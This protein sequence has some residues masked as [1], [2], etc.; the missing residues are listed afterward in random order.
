MATSPERWEAVK[1]LFEAAL[2]ED[3]ARRSSFLEERCNDAGVRAEVERLLA[4]HAQAGVFLSTPLLD[5][6]AL[7][8]DGAAADRRLS[9]GTVLAGRFRIVRFI[10]SGGMGEVYEAEDTELRERI[11]VKTIRREILLQPNSIARFRREVHL[12]RQVTHRNVC[13]IFD[14]FRHKRGKDSG[15]DIVFISMEL[16]QGD[17]LGKRLKDSEPVSTEEALPLIRQMGAALAAALA[18]GIIHRDFKPQ[19]VLLVSM[20]G[21]DR[22]RAVVTDFGLALQ[23]EISGETP[24]FSTGRGLL[25]TPAYMSPE[26][27]EGRTA[28]TASDISSDL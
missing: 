6:F 5:N 19:N 24:S 15:D 13:R 3:S 9:E 16:L 20:P 12:A 23:S 7:E 10:A 21:K 26:Q 2:E 28:T 27:V 1:E 22:K 11:A 8:S 18:A 4:E 25:G 14:L 17:H